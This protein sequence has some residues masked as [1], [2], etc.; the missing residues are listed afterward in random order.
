MKKSGRNVEGSGVDSSSDTYSL[1]VYK[2]KVFDYHHCFRWIGYQRANCE[3][4]LFIHLQFKI[5]YERNSASA[6]TTHHTQKKEMIRGVG[7]L[8]RSD[9]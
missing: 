1:A 6:C 9:M 5:N 7:N 4:S 8:W 3:E 2:F